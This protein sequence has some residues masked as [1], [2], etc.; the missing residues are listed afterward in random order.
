MS[1]NTE[2]G[3]PDVLMQAKELLDRYAKGVY[4]GSA[5]NRGQQATIVTAAAVLSVASELRDI[6]N[7]LCD[8]VDAVKQE[9]V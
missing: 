1:E 6:H 2:Q 8:L 7:V 9:E 4:I 3:R 5:A